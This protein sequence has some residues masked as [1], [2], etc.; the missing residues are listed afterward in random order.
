MTDGFGARSAD[1]QRVRRLARLAGLPAATPGADRAAGRPPSAAPTG[2]STRSRWRS[3]VAPARCLFDADGNEYLDAYNNVALGR[4]LHPHVV[5]EAVYRQMQALNTNTRYLQQS[6]SSDFS[7][8]CC[9]PIPRSW[10]KCWM[11]PTCTGSESND[12]AL[13]VANYYTGRQRGSSSPPTRI[14]VSPPSASA[15]LAIPGCKRCHWRQM[16]GMRCCRMPS[17]SGVTWVSTCAARGPAPRSRISER[18]GLRVVR[19]R[20]RSPSSRQTAFT[21]I[22]PGS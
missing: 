20:R 16:S 6:S 11:S 17:A 4:P 2:S 7:D 15:V 12:L 19:V 14:T 10:G 3:S 13:R 22:P 21:P 18:H 5:P 8:N 9:R 1:G